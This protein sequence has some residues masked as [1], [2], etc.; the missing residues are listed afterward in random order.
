[1][2][3]SSEKLAVYLHRAKGGAERAM[4]AVEGALDDGDVFVFGELLDLDSVKEVR[5]PRWRGGDISCTATPAPHSS[6]VG[7]TT[8]CGSC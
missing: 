3:S 6:R 2:A 1:M 4:R 5:A 8:P 7:S